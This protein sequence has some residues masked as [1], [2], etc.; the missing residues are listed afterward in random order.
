M[1]VCQ[2]RH[3]GN[4]GCNAAAAARPPSGRAT[5][6][7][8]QAGYGL[9]NSRLGFS[10]ATAKAYNRQGREE[11]PRRS[12]RTESIQKAFTTKDTKVHEG[13]H[14]LRRWLGILTAGLPPRLTPVL[15]SWKFLRS[16]LW[17][18]GSLFRRLRHIFERW[19]RQRRGLCRRHRGDWR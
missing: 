16:G 11:R 17:R 6:L 15:P 18:R 13:L 3:D 7:F 12:Q 4:L 9:S 14:G 8:L 19:R 1:R 5:H 2:F 10:F